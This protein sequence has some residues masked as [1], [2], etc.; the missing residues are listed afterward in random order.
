MSLVV[1]GDDFTICMAGKTATTDG[2]PD[3]RVYDEGIP[4]ETYYSFYWVGSM[5][6]WIEVW[7]PPYEPVDVSDYEGLTCA[8]TS[9]H[10]WYAHT[11]ITDARDPGDCK[12]KYI[13]EELTYAAFNYDVC[14][15]SVTDGS[16][17][18]TCELFYSGAD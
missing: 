10:T 11:A 13:D 7:E 6:S 5:G 9:D 12:Q 2:Y 14:I 17:G 16:G 4:G 18:V 1:D 8:P 3:P 15:L